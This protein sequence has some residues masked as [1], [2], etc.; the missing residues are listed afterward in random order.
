VLFV[1][2]LGERQALPL[3][4]AVRMRMVMFAFGVL[5][6][7]M[8]AEP[9]ISQI[10]EMGGLVHS[11]SA[12]NQPIPSGAPELTSV[13]HLAKSE[14]ELF[15]RFGVCRARGTDRQNC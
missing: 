2:P 6:A 5:R 3:L 7:A 9:A 4:R 13:C 12:A 8:F 15:P 11:I 1:N 14:P 10:E